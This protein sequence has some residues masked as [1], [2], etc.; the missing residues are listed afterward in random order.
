MVV[1]YIMKSPPTGGPTT[2][3]SEAEQGQYILKRVLPPIF[4]AL[5]KL[6]GRKVTER[7]IKRIMI[8]RKVCLMGVLMCMIAKKP[9]CVL[10]RLSC[11]S[12]L[13]AKGSVV[14]DPGNL[15]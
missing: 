4:A 3:N 14:G 1:G 10:G 8:L 11:G 7:I 13:Q 12:V 2:I 15:L 5:T 6:A 9:R